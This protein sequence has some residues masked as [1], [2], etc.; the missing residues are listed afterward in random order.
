MD[1]GGDGNRLYFY[2]PVAFIKNVSF[3]SIDSEGKGN[4][5]QRHAYL[6]YV[7]G[8]ALLKR[9]F[10][11]PHTLIALSNGIKLSV[12]FISIYFIVR[13]LIQAN[14]KKYTRY[15]VTEAAS[16]LSGFFYILSTGSEKLI[17]FWAKALHSHDQIFLNP[18]M[19]LLL[20]R[21][22]LTKNA[23]YL[24]GLLLV[25]FVFSLNFSMN[26]APP[27]FAFYPIAFLFLLLYTRYVR[28]ITLPIKQ[29]TIGFCIFV[30]LQAFHLIPSIAGLLTPNSA[31]NSVVFKESVSGGV[32]YFMA[33]HGIGKA[34]SSFFLSSPID[35]FR[36][37]AGI[38]PFI[39]IAGYLSQRKNRNDITLLSIFFLLSFFLVTA[40]ITDGGLE[41]YRRLFYVP[42]FSMFRN[43][44]SQWAY[45]FIFFY[46]LLFGMSFSAVFDRMKSRFVF[47]S[48]AGMLCTFVVSFWPFINGQLVDRVLW[49]SKGVKSAFIMDPKYERTLEYIRSLPQDGKILMLPLT[50]N[51]NQV[52]YGLNDAAYLGPS[53]ISIL[54]S[55]RSFSG[56]QILYPNPIPELIMQFSREKNYTALS[57]I[58]SYLNIRYVYYN[59]D[60]NI[61]ERK[62]PNFPNSYMMTS[63]PKTQAEYLAFVDNLPTHLLYANGP[64]H[65][66]E[67]DKR[68]VRPEV[69]VP[70]KVYQRDVL[71]AVTLDSASTSAF[72]DASLCKTTMSLNAI[73]SDAYEPPDVEVVTQ[74]VN[75]TKYILHIRQSKSDVPYLLIFQNS[76][77]TGWKLT[78]DSAK[79][80]S[81]DAHIQIN[82]YA[83]AWFISEADHVGKTEYTMTLSLETQKY[84][85]YGVAVTTIAVL[86]LLFFMIRTV[87][88]TT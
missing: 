42:G 24:W 4:V 88:H 29:G 49:G 53:S 40:N 64:F 19:F 54:T 7:A 13:E 30:G 73:C 5:E 32:N 15:L 62:F 48:V 21:Y 81:E 36:W 11:S 84:F 51:F 20:L 69:Y 23:W 6:I 47:L 31:S 22:F 82:A 58:F 60:P 25:S 80:V 3:Y 72:I 65:I 59:S 14:K 16:I 43:F 61:Y 41:L 71:Q 26:S 68:T 35:S 56:Y 10:Q 44:S 79:M 57:Q 76:F 12:G 77:H 66:Y 28:K 27:F 86:V 87:I 70:T 63:L 37:S 18:L 50:D 34:I 45:L 74:K 2:D 33:V 85:Y 9:I 8:I 52:V 1:L 46:A 75:P 78:T 83:N 55:K 38:A 17:F 67:L 39:V